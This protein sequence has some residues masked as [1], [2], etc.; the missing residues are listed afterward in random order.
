MQSMPPTPLRPAF[1]GFP[2]GPTTCTVAL[3]A[4]LTSSASQHASH[5]VL[6]VFIAVLSHVG[7]LTSISVITAR[8][9]ASGSV[10]PPTQPRS[11]IGVPSFAEAFAR[12]TSL[13][14]NG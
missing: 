11:T 6:Q 8:L 1:I 7:T 4:A 14:S 12:A 2:S 9:D 3:L 13:A 5:G 10:D